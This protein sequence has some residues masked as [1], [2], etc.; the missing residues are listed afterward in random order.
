MWRCVNSQR[1]D[2]VSSAPDIKE[3]FNEF[4]NKFEACPLKG[5]DQILRGVCPQV[6]GLHLVET[7]CVIDSHKLVQII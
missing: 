4:W 7:G 6:Y 1:S 5:R 2:V 3:C